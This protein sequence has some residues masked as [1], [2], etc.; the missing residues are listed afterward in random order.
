MK[1]KSKFSPG[2]LFRE[3]LIIGYLMVFAE[4]LHKKVLASLFARIF[5]SYDRSCERFENA[6]PGVIRKKSEK[7]RPKILGAKMRFASLTESSVFVR[8]FRATDSFF[9]NMEI[10]SLGAGIFFCGFFSAVVYIVK[11]YILSVESVGLSELVTGVIFMLCSVPLILAKTTFRHSLSE[12]LFSKYVLSG[13]FDIKAEDGAGSSGRRSSGV[14]IIL[15]TAAGLI[16]YFVPI[17][18]VLICAVALPMIPMVMHIPEFG[19]L[20]L[21]AAL[22]FA[23]TMLLAGMLIFTALSF[24]LKAARGKRTVK[25]DLCDFAVLFFMAVML[26][27]GVVSVSFSSSIQP[28]L[29]YVCFMLAYFLA[30]NMIKTT[31]LTVHFAKLLGIS[32]L[33]SSLYGIYQNFFGSAASGWHDSA[34][35]SDISTRVFSTFD[36]PNVFGEYLILLIPLGISML[37]LSSGTW[38]RLLSAAVVL[39]AGLSL[40]Y[41]WSRGAWLGFIISI[42]LY[43]L[44]MNR[45][46][47][48]FY[49]VLLLASPIAL[50]FMP[51]SVTNRFGS[52]GN[53]NDT[54]TNYRV[55]IWKAV[56][57]MIRD[58]FFSGIGVGEGAFSRIYPL[59]ALSGIESAP[60]SHNL[61]LQIT[62]ETGAI[63]LAAFIIAMF[64]IIKQ[65][66]SS[67]RRVY[68]GSRDGTVYDFGQKKFS[69]LTVGAVC[70]IIAFLV[71]GMTDYVWYN[72][73]VFLLFWL[74]CGFA[75]A[76]CK[77]I[78]NET[79]P[80]NY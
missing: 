2:K 14:M 39:S 22:P 17:E 44:F 46:T 37:L 41:T 76:S 28:A 63:G 10:S 26:M 34:M 1:A 52:I 21:T 80:F 59:Y 74:V 50:R 62:V 35:F 47:I 12:S 61:Y 66:L 56:V 24:L 72:Y 77:A 33:I 71:M 31:H 36:N 40:V 7:N 29:L 13:L 16:T 68:E 58:T 42:A 67:Y 15:G 78:E 48:S 65:C 20:A 70:G 18:Y 38:R 6:F 73:R 75:V 55:N 3:S 79:C 19:L 53:L 11:Q 8:F 23:P 45:H 25:F 57:K 5:T 60:H 4:F 32:L 54:S 43:L 27:G 30:V 9:L 69:F 51:S 49:A 64:L